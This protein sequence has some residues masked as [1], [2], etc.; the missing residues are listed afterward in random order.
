MPEGLPVMSP[1]IREDAYNAL[2]AKY[3]EAQTIADSAMAMIDTFTTDLS[4]LLAADT[5]TST[6]LSDLAGLVSAM[7]VYTPGVLVMP[8]TPVA[9]ELAGLPDISTAITLPIAPVRTVIDPA[10]MPTMPILPV[11][12]AGDITYEDTAFVSTL[13]DAILAKLEAD[14]AAGGTGLSV[15]AE[16]ALFAR[17]TDRVSAANAKLISE[18]LTFFSSRGFDEPPGGSA[19][20]VAELNKEAAQNLTDISRDI[21]SESAKLAQSYSIAVLQA[22]VSAND[23]SARISHESS[24]RQLEAAKASLAGNLGVFQADA[25]NLISAA[26][27]SIALF[28]AQMQSDDLDAKLYLANIQ[29]QNLLLEA[30]KAQLAAVVSGNELEVKEFMAELDGYKTKIQTLVIPEELKAKQVEIDLKRYSVAS[31]LT[32]KAVELELQTMIKNLALRVEGLKAQ[33]AVAAQLAAS[34]LNGVNVTASYGFSGNVAS[35]YSEDG[36]KAVVSS[37]HIYNHSIEGV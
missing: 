29:A 14:L 25:L 7:P 3:L 24:L 8:S 16:A 22:A 2:S 23:V 30:N 19:A 6:L 4:A 5:E 33:V 35:Q 34:A 15:A 17:A 10:A 21:L 12:P 13:N 32:I 1:T 27:T 36:T 11:V 9:P 37:Q 18:T 20:K 28:Q 26:Q 31:E